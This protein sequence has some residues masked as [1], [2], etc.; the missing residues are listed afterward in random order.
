MQAGNETTDVLVL[1][2]RK[3]SHQKNIDNDSSWV[4]ISTSLYSGDYDQT[5]SKFFEI[6]LKGNEGNLAID[7]GKISED[8]DGNGILNTEDIP[9]A[10]LTLGNGF[11]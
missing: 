6:W 2:Y 11:S 7:L 8:W 10:G 5:Q 1:R 9:E 4:G 3:R